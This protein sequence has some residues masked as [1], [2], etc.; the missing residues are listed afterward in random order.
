MG[1]KQPLSAE[2]RQSEIRTLLQVGRELSIS[3]LALRFGASEMTI[4]RDLSKLQQRGQVLRTHG[5]VVPADRMMF[6]FD[7]AAR[8]RENLAA[9]R[10]IA[11]EALKLIN[12]PCRIILDTGTTALQLAYELQSF[13]DI[14][15]I[16][17]SLA[18]AS[19]LQFAEGVQ[20]VLLGGIIRKG[21]P[22]LTGALTESMLEMFAADIAFQGAD[23]IDTDGFCYNRDLRIAK[24]DQKIRQRA[25]HVYVLADSSKLNRT[26]L[27]RHGSIQQVDG[28]ITDN[29]AD[30]DF[31]TQ[32]KT[33]GT[34]V[35][36]AEL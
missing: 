29:K 34:S 19:A 31:I 23:G 27:V 10:A 25:Q 24:V 14:S 12:P 26:A 16:T 28:L 8:Q 33:I 21:S 15:V 4:R 6:E 22:D 18:V 36:I 30:M 9:K 13:N 7:F 35:I 3:E 5:G 20:T 2:Q 11:R 1:K 17:P 32:L